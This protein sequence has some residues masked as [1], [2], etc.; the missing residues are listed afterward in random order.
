MGERYQ[1]SRMAS[2]RFRARALLFEQLPASIFGRRN[3]NGPAQRH[4]LLYASENSNDSNN[5][6][7]SALS[8]NTER[9]SSLAFR[10]RLKNYDLPPP[11]VR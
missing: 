9:V 4:V 5:D 11:H 2:F 1:K 8:M 6:K 3:S 7:Q 10:G